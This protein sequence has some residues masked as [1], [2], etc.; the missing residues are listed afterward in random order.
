MDFDREM[1]LE[2]AGIDA[3]E[4]SLMDE[5]ERREALQD[6]YL[7]PDD[8]DHIE[9][10][11]SFTAWTDLQN[12][13]IRLSELDYMDEDEK[14]DKLRDAGLD[15]DDYDGYLSYI[16]SCTS[17]IVP[18]R[19]NTDKHIPSVFA[20][21]VPVK[22]KA[23]TETKEEKKV[24]RRV[25]QFCGV[26]FEDNYKVWYYRTGKLLPELGDYVEVPFGSARDVRK[27]KV[28]SFGDYAEE[29]VP[30]P[31][32]EAQYIFRVLTAG[33]SPDSEKIKQEIGVISPI[34]DTAEEQK[35]ILMCV[36]QDKKR[37]DTEG[38]FLRSGHFLPKIYDSERGA[39]M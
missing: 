12:A 16:P 21:T 2:N 23:K 24:L 3:F 36:L 31:V 22:L 39:V 1:K 14:R 7:D 6:A 27:A 13:G 28:I 25:Y 11:S 38:V 4:F 19:V 37:K 9:Y 15:S 17:Y 35:R 32:K 10:D 34:E 30:I 29:V 26:L 33:E 5:D 20:E 18:D 8:F